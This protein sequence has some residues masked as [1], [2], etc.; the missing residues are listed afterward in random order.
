MPSFSCNGDWCVA[1]RSVVNQRVLVGAGFEQAAARL[2]LLEQEGVSIIA[3]TWSLI[4]LPEP[5]A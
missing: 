2:P 1:I 3:D 4:R 5:E